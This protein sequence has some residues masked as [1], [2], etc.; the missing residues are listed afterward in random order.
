[1]SI[2]SS[3]AFRGPLLP[4]VLPLSFLPWATTCLFCVLLRIAEVWLFLYIERKANSQKIVIKM[5]VRKLLERGIFPACFLTCE[6]KEDGQMHF[7]KRAI[8]VWLKQAFC[9]SSLCL[10]KQHRNV[11]FFFFW[12]GHAN[13]VHRRLVSFNHG[14]LHST[15]HVKQCPRSVPF[16]L[17]VGTKCLDCS[18]DKELVLATV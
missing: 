9:L 15:E 3:Q 4:S 6:S 16:N 17:L 10:L 11:S 13:A 7:W 18:K 14:Y 8:H 2:S 12:S 1:M 5:C